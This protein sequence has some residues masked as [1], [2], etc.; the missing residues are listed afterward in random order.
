MVSASQ[1]PKETNNEQFPCH[2]QKLVG[3]SEGWNRLY[4]A[5]EVILDVTGRRL[6]LSQNIVCAGWNVTQDLGGN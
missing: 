3:S 5:E 4:V 6:H 2:V 1:I